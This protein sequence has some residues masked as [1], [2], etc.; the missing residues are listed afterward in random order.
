MSD[1][2]EKKKHKPLTLREKYKITELTALGR[3][4]I[5]LMYLI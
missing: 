3:K 4:N 1:L 2:S 5:I